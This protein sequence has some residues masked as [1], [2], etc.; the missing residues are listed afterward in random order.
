MIKRVPMKYGAANIKRRFT[1]YVNFR[2]DDGV[3]WS[4]CKTPSIASGMKALPLSK[5]MAQEIHLLDIFKSGALNLTV[6]IP[7]SNLSIM[8]YFLD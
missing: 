5:A 1:C 6:H 2:M 3:S 8:I 7:G 4:S